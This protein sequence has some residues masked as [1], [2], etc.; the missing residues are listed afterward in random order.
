MI[1][2]SQILFWFGLTLAAATALYHTSDRT[3]E[4]DHQLRDIDAAIE[5]EQQTIHVLNAE[6]V[7]LAN[8][9]RVETEA[10]KHLDL[11]PTAT[12][13]VIALSNL[14]DALPTRREAMGSVAV[15][16]PPIATIKTSLALPAPSPVAHKV[17]VAVENSHIKDRLIIQ[18]ADARTASAQSDQIGALIGEL[19]SRQ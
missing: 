14:A 15:S 13:Q 3:R 19:G 11:R 7:Y 10:K 12:A 4:L 18:R 9:A 16:T 8:P 1:R 6:W 2:A 5:S 17:A